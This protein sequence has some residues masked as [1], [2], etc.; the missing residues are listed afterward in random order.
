MVAA[1]PELKEFANGVSDDVLASP[2]SRD[3]RNRMINEAWDNLT[4]TERKYYEAWHTWK[5]FKRTLPPW[6]YFETKGK[7]MVDHI[8]MIEQFEKMLSS[9]QDARRKAED[10]REERKNKQQDNNSRP[11]FQNRANK[12]TS[13]L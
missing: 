10:K 9:R 13:V 6:R 8:K 11:V 5:T 1:F 12:T 3:K 4:F 2:Q 7:I